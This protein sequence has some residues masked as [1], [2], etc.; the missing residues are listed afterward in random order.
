MNMAAFWTAYFFAIGASIGSFLNV[1]V[2]R[3]PRGESVVRPG[4]RCPACGGSIA[5][6]QNIPI[7]SWLLLRGRCAKCGAPFS[8][9]YMLVEL[10]TALLFAGCELRWGHG[11]RGLVYMALCAAL[12]AVAFIDLDHFIIPDVITIPGTVAGFACAWLFLPVAALDPVYGFAAGF[13]IFFVI[14]LLAPGGMGGGDI[15]LMGMVGAFLGLKGALITIFLGSC[16]G[17]AFGLAGMLF[18]G[19]GR[20]SKIPFGP[21][22]VVGALI[23]VFWQDEVV[24]LYL[25]LVFPPR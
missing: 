23:A 18:Y 17:A 22:L 25:A 1:V 20:K 7:L 21:Y 15:K 8:P 19:K 24:D 2:H 16:V 11:A 9:R 10:I 5:W 4:S 3:L 6:R 14:A 13:G 12:V